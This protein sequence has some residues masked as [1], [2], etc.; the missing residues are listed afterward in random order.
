MSHPTRRLDA[1]IHQP[2]RLGILT[3]T[4][5]TKRVDFVTLRD[6]LEVTDGNLSRHLATLEEAG[7]V[8]IEK[9]F[10]NRKPRT[11]ISITRAGRKA[12]SAEITALRDIVAAA[13]GL[14]PRGR[15]ALGGRAEGGGDRSRRPVDV[16]GQRLGRKAP[17]RAGQP[18][19]GDDVPG[20]VDHGS[21]D[22]AQADLELLGVEGK[23][24][25]ADAGERLEQRLYRRQRVRRPARELPAG[26]ARA[27]LGVAEAGQQRLAGGGGVRGRTLAD[28]A[29]HPHAA[30]AVHDADRDH[31]GAVERD[32]VPGL[33]HLV[34][35]RAQYRD[36]DLR[37]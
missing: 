30:P 28:R 22:A 10:E 27:H 11:W 23:P 13:D 21:G 35:Q 6:M 29:V 32:D 36:G 31:L 26:V 33:A 9:E 19:R 5:E 16:G 4:R 17:G 3:V 24:A 7:Y 34:D 8:T 15:D 37:Q 2:V 18:D 1:T 25:L 12:L 14:T 20:V